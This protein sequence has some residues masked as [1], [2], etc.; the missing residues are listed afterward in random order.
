MKTGC[1]MQKVKQKIR[2]CLLQKCHLNIW[3]HVHWNRLSLVSR[4]QKRNQD[5]YMGYQ[6]IDSVMSELKGFRDNIDVEF[7]H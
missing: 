3:Y 2:D 5:I 6:M 1:G 7:G 4:L